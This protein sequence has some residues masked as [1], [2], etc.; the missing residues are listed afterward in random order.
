MIKKASKKLISLLLV[1]MLVVS[2]L[3]I[4]ALALENDIETNDQHSHQHMDINTFEETL[5]LKEVKAQMDEILDKYLGAR[6]LPIEAVEDAVW[7]MEDD[8]LI[9]AWEECEELCVK[10]EPMTD[11]EV[12]FA[13]LYE[14]TETF[15]YFYEVLSDIFNGDF[16]FFAA[17]GTHEPVEGVTVGVS[18]ATDNNMSS[19]AVTVTAK[20]SAGFMGIGASTKTATIT[21][22]NESG[23]TATVSFD[24]TA[25]TINELKIDGTVHT[26]A[27]GNF[28]K[29][30]DA[31]ESF[32]ITITTAKNGTVNKLVMNNFAIVA[33][34]DESNVTFEF[35]ST[36]GSVT[37]G[38][39]AVNNGDAVTMSKDGETVV[40]TAASGVTFLGWINTADHKILSSDA[41]F[42]LQPADDMTVKPV[43][44]KTS[45]WFL[46]NANSLYEG[47]NEAMTAVASVANKTVVLANNAT[48]PAGDYT[49]PTGVTLLIPFDAANTLYTDTPGSVDA[50]YN[51][52]T[53]Y[54]TL[55]LA[56]GANITVNGAISVPAKIT[57]SNGMS[58]PINAVGMVKMNEN[59]T[60]TVNSGANLYVWGFIIGSGSVTIKNGGTVYECF[61]VTNWRGGDNTSSMVDNKQGVFPMNQYYVQNVEVPMTMEAGAIENGYMAVKI[62]LVGVQGSAVPFIG[63][64]GMFNINSGSLT[65]DYD[66]S[67]D[68]LNIAINGEIS[69]QSLSISMKLSL[70]GTKTINSKNYEL[71]VTSN[72]SVA[73]KDGGKV[74]ITQDIAILPGAEMIVEK[75][76]LCELGEGY[77]IY[78]YDADEWA[79]GY[80]ATGNAYVGAAKVAP[81]KYAPG[82]PAS[83]PFH[84]ANSDAHIHVAGTIDASAGNVYVTASGANVTAEDGAVIKLNH[85]GTQTVTYQIE[86]DGKTLDYVD[87]PIKSV[88]LIENDGGVGGTYE[89]VNNA[90]IKTE[91][92]HI[93][94]K[95]SVPAGCENVGYTT[96]TCACGDSYTA[97]EVAA[98][99]HTEVI[100]EAVA[101]TC[102][103]TGLTEG[104]HCSVCGEILVA[105]EVVAALGHDYDAVVTAPTCTE[106][107]YTTYTCACGDSYVADE[108]DALGHTEVIDEAVAP[109][110]T[111]TGLTEGKHCSVCGEIL[112]AQEIVAAL[113]HSYEAVVTAP[114]CTE[115]GY[116]TYTC[117]C[118]DSYVADEVDALGHT[119]VIDEAVAPTCTAT[120]LTE[121]KHCSVCGEIL[122]AQEIVAALGHSY[123]AVV[124]APTCTEA[125]YTTYTCA[126]GDSYV[127]DEVDALGHTEVI[128]EAVAPTC[129]ATGLTEGKHCSVCGEIL[130]AQEE[131]AALGHSYEAVVTAP[132]CTETGY[133]TYTCACGDNYVADE[134]DA[135]GHTEVIDEAVAPTCTETGLTVGSHCSVCGEIL[136]AQEEVAA[137]G[138]SYEAVV[139]A[140]TCTEAGYTTYTCSN[141]GDS[142]VADEVDALGHSDWS[143][144]EITTPA[145]ITTPGIKTRT[146]GLCGATETMEYTIETSGATGDVTWRLENGTLYI[147][148]AG[149][150]GDY[151]NVGN[152]A[153]WKE[154]YS[155]I[156]AIVIGDEVT[157][158]GTRAFKSLNK[159]TSVIFG[160]AVTTTGYECFQGC[161]ALASVELN[162][163]ITK[164][165]S[166]LFYG[167]SSLET[168]DI[169]A[170]VDTINTRVFKNCSKLNGVVLPEA[171]SNSSYEVFMGCTSLESIN[172]PAKYTVVAPAMFSG[173]TSLKEVYIPK[174]VI[175]I[176]V[177]AFMN[178]TA[179]ESVTFEDEDTLYGGSDARI[180]SNAFEGCSD[181]LTL[182]SC[183][184]GYVNEYANARGIKFESTTSTVFI[185][186]VDGEGNATVT[187]MRGATSNITIPETIDG[188]TVVAVGGFRYNTATRVNLPTTVTAINSRA[189]QDCVNLTTVT[190]LDNVTKIS[191]NAFN[192]CSALTNITF[193]SALTSIS[194]STFQN[195][196]ALGEIY[197]P[198]TVTSVN[199]TAFT[200]CTNAVIKTQANSAAAKAAAAQG[201]TVKVVTDFDYTVNEDGESVTITGYYGNGGALVIPDEINGYKVTAINQRAFKG[202]TS[203]TSVVIG[204]TVTNI[205]YEAFMNCTNI[206]N[207]TVGTGV[208]AV[209][210]SSFGGLTK[211]ETIT[212][213]GSGITFNANALLNSTSRLVICGVVGS[214][215]ETFAIEKGFTFANKDT[216]DPTAPKTI[217]FSKGLNIT[218][219]ET[220]LSDNQWNFFE[221]GYSV[222][223]DPFTYSNI[224]SKGFDYVRIPVNFYTVYYE[225]PTGNYKY[226]S[227]QIMQAVDKGIQYAFDNDLY[228]MLDFHG[229]FYIGSEADD[230]EQFLYCWTQVAERYKDYSDKLCFEL[231]NEPWYTNGAP[232]KYLWD[233]KLNDMQCEA[234]D[235][236]RNTGSNNTTRLIV[237]CTADGNKAWKLDKLN[238]P[239]DDKYL[240]VA[241]HEYEPHAFTHQNFSWAGLGG[242][243]TSLSAAGGFS[244]IN[245][246]F[247]MIKSFMEETGIPVIL[248][249]FG[250]NLAKASDE[251]VTTYLS[252]ITKLCKDNNMPWAYWGY[253]STDYNSEGGMALYRKNSYWGSKTWDQTAL[254]ALFSNYQ[255]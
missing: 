3:P 5:L 161:S 96:Y 115:A 153:P 7:S 95:T 225:A 136:V 92:T 19:G 106:A 76:G 77:N 244:A 42:T 170:T 228:V 249:E 168:I 111:A 172:I 211:L 129:T 118:G 235:I 242:Q 164:L 128:D 177:Q 117:A 253:H 209:G 219:M 40:A 189:F 16:A 199:N 74:K 79:L 112:V 183:M 39:N 239:T 169:P 89:Y 91:C 217:P 251:D 166:N 28:S 159:V 181:K 6:V 105:Q 255:D 41:S 20:G 214:S 99:G 49:I 187:G 61:Q 30:L 237:C 70:I 21:I 247:S 167:C 152:V 138:H 240:A 64:N 124:T 195:C 135:L 103:A 246:D 131:V 208:T 33:L 210:A 226:T 252:G 176:R 54:R 234:I 144:W 1:V 56:S 88:Q 241:I 55:T 32:V 110:C 25:T 171:L 9:S 142:Y 205:K 145:T 248:N 190:G 123:E 87:I 194:T 35:D 150:M 71:P 204:N 221:D 245:Y 186:T 224:K 80:F 160:T 238:L 254:D 104:K 52:P 243:T 229:W 34:K 184:A 44:A 43:F 203:I 141:C 100:D 200:G 206:T 120:G 139:T 130:V 250:M 38:G 63:P 232:Q 101:P 69:M 132:T 154:L 173:C 65:K 140:P 188:H 22:Y 26:A 127:A 86:Q 223:S 182:K 18:G 137:L 81:V 48:L 155:E 45:P 46:I 122:V 11:A 212:F 60:I 47:L 165:G 107:G 31:G 72:I 85:A 156:T 73:I 207:I 134:I 218:G 114:T 13:K 178:C 51:V 216:Y 78:I 175:K 14:S 220:F 180:S 4:Q 125:G 192:G 68:R 2:I 98:L 230:Y 23:V 12:Y 93:Y 108:V 197:V 146:C 213:E 198:N 119:E 62:S 215:T 116:T 185:Y 75:G 50:T 109:T 151:S 53:A 66:E 121:G 158:I 133:T 196:T 59:S 67:T 157:Y 90:W 36:L 58:A 143:E 113:G 84:N 29:V 231:L 191:S 148:G 222:V 202:N 149:A 102:T 94:E 201:V 236:I 57:A 10:A 233:S 8:A 179:L 27:S 37:V 83:V 82:K 17:T 97:D 162:D 147:E 15:G 163:V 24:W 126:C 174:T 227:E 193:G